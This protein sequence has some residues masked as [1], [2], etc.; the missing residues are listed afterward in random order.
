MPPFML[1]AVVGFAGFAGYKLVAALTGGGDKASRSDSHS[2]QNRSRDT[3]APARD[4]GNL[5]WDE[6]AGVYRP[7]QKRE[8]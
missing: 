4:L 8:G 2:S 5:E 7:R 3:A 1:L 6:T